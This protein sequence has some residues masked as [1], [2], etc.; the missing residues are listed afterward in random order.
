MMRVDYLVRSGS[1][2]GTGNGVTARSV[3][4]TLR[5]ADN[6]RII[7]LSTTRARQCNARKSILRQLQRDRRVNAQQNI[8]LLT[9]LELEEEQANHEQEEE[10][11]TIESEDATMDSDDTDNN[12]SEEDDVVRVGGVE[13]PIIAKRRRTGEQESTTVTVGGR[14]SCCRV[15]TLEED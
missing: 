15:N 7:E 4:F 10:A 6:H 1:K 3:M 14:G 5:K 12:D 8:V 2:M 9:R 13:Y 11:T